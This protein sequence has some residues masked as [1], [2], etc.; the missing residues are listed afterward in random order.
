MIAAASTRSAA[1]GEMA[2]RRLPGP[3]RAKSRVIV[4]FLSIIETDYRQGIGNAVQNKMASGN[5]ERQLEVI[6]AMYLVISG[7][8]S[9]NR[10]FI[11]NNFRH[12]NQT[13]QAAGRRFL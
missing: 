4:L 12:E 9:I 3:K 7:R 8:Y 1:R 10:D 11:L 13:L 2:E 5:K 6:L